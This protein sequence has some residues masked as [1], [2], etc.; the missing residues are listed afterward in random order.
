[1]QRST[2]RSKLHRKGDGNQSTRRKCIVLT[3]CNS[4]PILFENLEELYGIMTQRV[5]GMGHGSLV[6]PCKAVGRS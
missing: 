2:R 5:E 6:Y 3:H 1:M 4:F